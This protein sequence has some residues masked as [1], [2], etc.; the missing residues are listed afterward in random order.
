MKRDIDRW[1]LC[2]DGRVVLVTCWQILPV[3]NMAATKR[4][5]ETAKLI[6]KERECLRPVKSALFVAFS[7]GNFF[8]AHISCALRFQERLLLGPLFVSRVIDWFVGRT[9][10]DW[11]RISCRHFH[12]SGYSFGLA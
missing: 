2:C 11:T 9:D 5:A 7:G 4:R 3:R 12:S 8:N 1:S 10:L 6:G